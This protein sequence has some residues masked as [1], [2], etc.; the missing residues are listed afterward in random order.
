MG[1][2]YSRLWNPLMW[3]APRPRNTLSSKSDMERIL[4]STL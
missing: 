3:H 1:T 2:I 4:E